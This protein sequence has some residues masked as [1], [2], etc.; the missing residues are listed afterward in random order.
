MKLG[1]YYR[2]I[3]TDKNGKVVK[4]T[5]WKKSRSFVLQF[6][7]HIQFMSHTAYAVIRTPIHITD[8][9]DVSQLMRSD[10]YLSSVFSIFAPDNIDT[11]GFVVGTDDG[12]LY[13]LANG[14]YKLG[15]EIAHGTGAGQLDYGAHSQT[16]PAVVGANVDWVVSRTFYNGSGATITVKEIGIYCSTMN[17]AA[18]QCFFCIVRDIITSISVANTQTLTV[19][20]TFRTTV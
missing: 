1:L 13:A 18:T 8:V 16:A 15:A 6:L 7:Q 4:R 10:P 14:N 11:Y 5:H 2:C 20:Y 12:T 9:G 19:Q 3:V 17:Q